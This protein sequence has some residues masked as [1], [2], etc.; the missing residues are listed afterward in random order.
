MAVVNKKST[1]I[2]V[3]DASPPRGLNATS[4]ANGSLRESIAVVEV[5]ADDDDSSIY[6]FCRVRSSD[7]ISQ[8]TVFNDAIVGG[9]AFDCGPYDTA[10]NGSAVVS[11]QLFASAVDLTSGTTLGVEML[12]EALDIANLE[13]PIWQLLA[14][15]IDPNKMYDVCLKAT[16]VGSG[17]GTI[18]MR[19]R[20][21]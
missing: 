2:T 1:Q 13:K 9:S 20:Y 10:E 17:A 7:R 8:L 15:T 4:V 14:L 3:A 12:S 11:G 19:T 21:V 18:T 16:T 5:A 6:R